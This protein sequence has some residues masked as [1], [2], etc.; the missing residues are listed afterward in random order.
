MGRAWRPPPRCRT[1][2]RSPNGPGRPSTGSTSRTAATARTASTRRPSADL[3]RALDY[4]GSIAP[5]EL[6]RLAHAVQ[7]RGDGLPE[8]LRQRYITRLRAAEAAQ[9]RRSRLIAAG[10]AA[11]VILAG[12]LIYL[13]VQAQARAR[14]AEQAA[15]A[16]SDM[17]ELGELDHAVALVK[18][19][20]AADPDL[21]KYPALVEVRERVEIAQGKESDRA[22]RF[23]QAMR[24]AESAPRL[25]QASRRAGDRPLAGPARHRE[26]GRSTNLVRRRAAALQAE[27][28]R[29]EKELAPRLDEVAR[30]V[31]RIEQQLK[32]AGPGRPDDRGDAGIDRRLPARAR[33]PRVG[34]GD[35]RRGR[36]GPGAQPLRSARRRPSPGWTGATSRPGS[37]TRSPRPS[38]IRPTAAAF[39]G[40]AELATALQAFIKA[41]PDSP[42]SR[43]F[44]TTLRDQPVWD[45]I[46]EWDRLTAGWRDGRAAVAPQEANVRAEQCRQFLVQ[47]PASPDFERATAY[48][49]AME[50]MSH[51]A[52]EG[53]GALGKLQKLMTDLLVDNLWMVTV[54][55]PA[56]GGPRHYYV[57]QQPARGAR[58]LRYLVGFDGKERTLTG[59]RRL[60]REDRR[61]A[62]D[63]DRRASSSRCSSRTRPRSTGRS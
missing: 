4:P 9:T 17:L 52:A 32:A 23:D 8:G 50:A 46:G 53:E 54:R 43:A 31:D 22:V 58:S 42:R 37:R 48:R 35:R 6:E 33:G 29:R 47:H 3:V 39:T 41:F 56:S 55:P 5:A 59:G 57:T 26:G 25:G 51:R 60:G 16:I 27:Q 19:L 7:A 45:A 62:A 40:S 20:E 11:G 34:R 1:T 13:A 61:V 24:E 10:S 36:A 44:T 15:T 30:A 14:E 28:G 49:H 12:T 18:K 63:E 38:P 2:T 21:L